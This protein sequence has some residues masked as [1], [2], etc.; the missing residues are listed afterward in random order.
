LFVQ[1]QQIHDMKV[2][3]VNEII[4]LDRSA[5]IGEGGEAEVYD[6]A[7]PFSGQVLKLWKRP[8]HPSYEG[9]TD[10]AVRNREAAARRLREYTDKLTQFPRALPPSVVSP[11]SLAFD[12][13]VVA[14]FTMKK[15]VNAELLKTLAQRSFKRGAGIDG[16]TV[17]EIF[18]DLHRTV[19]GIHGSKV[20]I[21]DF[22][23]LNV[24]VKDRQAFVLDAD[25]FQFEGF[26]CR[27]F[28]PRFVD[29]LICDPQGSSLVQVKPHSDYTDWYAFA[30]MLFEVLLS[31]HPYGGVYEP[32]RAGDRVP[33][34]ARPLKRLSVFS[35]DVIYPVKGIPYGHLPDD[36][37]Q[38][39]HNLLLR[40]ARGAFPE[41][42]LQNT[43]WT[44]CKSCGTE[45][46]RAHCPTCATPVPRAAVLETVVGA[47]TIK[48]LALYSGTLINVSAQG[49]AL[50]A[51]Y[52][53]GGTYK[54]DTGSEVLATPL[55]RDIKLRSV[56]LGTVAATNG[57]L[58]VLM[59]GEEPKTFAVDLFRGGRPVFDTNA[60][61]VYWVSDGRL[62]RDGAHGPKFLGTVIRNQTKI[63][64]GPRFGFGFSRAQG[65]QT[66]FTFDAEKAG[67]S[68]AR[69]LPFIEG[70]LLDVRCYFSDHAVWVV[71]AA[72]KHGKVRHHAYVLDAGG[73]L[74][75]TSSADEDDGT[76]LGSL[77]GKVALTLPGAQ[78]GEAIHAL[79][80]TSSRGL[81]RA[82]VDAG[83]IVQTRE[84]PDSRTVVPED[85][86]LFFTRQGLIAV[87]GNRADIVAIRR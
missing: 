52:W 13:N 20:V 49:G 43:R 6:L 86:H 30:L 76:W 84:Y 80:S 38:F 46:A 65:Y 40:D 26:P 15:V 21:G 87:S 17:M 42:L 71:A 78:A 37:L 19:T 50:R 85:A 63:W 28:T 31:V 10:E 47:V 83:G 8:S 75:G 5:L 73:A 68:E 11:Q 9:T 67:L 57:T 55:T 27:T 3:I 59:P 53:D 23:Y 2:T 22:N 39:Y 44:T 48:Q 69:S 34:D 25:S 62:L 64:A 32:K 36:I 82:E 1:L 56:G 54:R 29:P 7:A 24:L 70:E 12:G 45:H 72:K 4:T 58:A 41:R 81:V 66:A 14:G 51:V 61:H 33:L 77:R 35:P 60:H 18:R 79:I 74:L 16:N